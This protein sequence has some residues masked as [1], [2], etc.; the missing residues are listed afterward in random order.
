MMAAPAAKEPEVVTNCDH[1]V[2]MFQL[3]REGT[4][5]LQVSR[6]QIASLNA[7]NPVKRTMRRTGRK[8][9]PVPEK[10]LAQADRIAA[11]RQARPVSAIGFTVHQS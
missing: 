8:L 3:S 1:P 11:G 6:S 9:R 5:G 2:F 4:A 10:H 7:G